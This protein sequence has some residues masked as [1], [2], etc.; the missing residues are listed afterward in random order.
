MAQPNY[1]LLVQAMPAPAVAGPENVV[2]LD[3]QQITDLDDNISRHLDNISGLLLEH[4]KEKSVFF[5]AQR[6]HSLNFDFIFY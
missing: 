5:T 4:H 3:Q 1:R 2:D 6:Q